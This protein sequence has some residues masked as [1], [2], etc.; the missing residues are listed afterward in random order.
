VLGKELTF[1]DRPLP[2]DDPLQRQPV[3]AVAA[4]KLGW[5]PT[6]QLEEGISR[7]AAWFQESLKL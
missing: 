6:V 5:A 2:Q 4:E 1:E 3:I 7:A